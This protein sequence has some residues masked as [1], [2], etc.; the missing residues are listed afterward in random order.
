MTSEMSHARHGVHIGKSRPRTLAATWKSSAYY[1]DQGFVRAAEDAR[2][3]RYEPFDAYSPPTGVRADPSAGPHLSFLGLKEARREM[4]R[5]PMPFLRKLYSFANRYGHLGLFWEEYPAGPVLPYGKVF[6]AP[7]AI[8][9]G[10]SG[11]LRLLDPGTEGKERLLA[12]Q[13]RLDEEKYGP[14]FR[15]RRDAVSET[16]GTDPIALPSELVCFLAIEEELPQPNGPSRRGVPWSVVQEDYDA[17]LVLDGRSFTGVSV[18]C[19]REYI[20]LWGFH[21]DTFPFP[22]GEQ[23]AF[24][25]VHQ[26][27]EML[28]PDSTDEYLLSKLQNALG[29]GAVSPY[30]MIGQDGQMEQGWYCRNHLSALYLMVYLDKTG[31]AEYRK[32]QAPDC[33]RLFRAKPGS[34]R[35]YCPHPEGPSKPSKCG[36]RVT[37]QKSRERQRRKL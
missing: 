26:D 36:S 21:I 1:V 22:S 9:D 28:I 19:R 14:F 6:V 5:D 29:G 13:D 23:R 20:P 33:G 37:T 32:C 18:L 34:T 12:L 4:R 16:F 17:L 3:T 35:I 27:V 8:V 2:W 30:P 31:E 11:R 25:V 15:S 7:E 10:R 24:P